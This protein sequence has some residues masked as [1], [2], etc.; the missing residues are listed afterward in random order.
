MVIL[1]IL[2][3]MSCLAAIRANDV[4]GLNEG[5]LQEHHTPVRS[6]LLGGALVGLLGVLVPQTMFWG[7]YEIQTLADPSI[8]LPHIWPAG[9]IHGVSPF[10]RADYTAVWCDALLAVLLRCTKMCVMDVLH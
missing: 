5:F 4:D 8:K 7:E 10:P 2:N 6:G 3:I 9:G 1:N